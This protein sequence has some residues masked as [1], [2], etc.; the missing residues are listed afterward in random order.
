[1]RSHSLL[2]GIFPTQGSNPGLL[3][4]RWILYQLSHKGSPRI[5]EWV[6]YPF[7]SESFWPRNQSGFF[8]IAGGF[9][10]NWTIREAPKWVGS[11]TKWLGSPHP[12]S[13]TLSLEK[14]VYSFLLW[15]FLL[16]LNSTEISDPW[17]EEPA[18]PWGCKESY[19]TEWLTHT[20][21][22]YRE[23][24]MGERLYRNHLGHYLW[25]PF[26]DRNTQP[27]VLL[28]AWRSH[29]P[30]IRAEAHTCSVLRIA[31]LLCVYLSSHLHSFFSLLFLLSFVRELPSVRA[32]DLW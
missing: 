9:F 1:M 7:S 5:L 17:T 21:Q 32:G 16:S 28:G 13:S 11:W 3:L 12:R 30:S 18:C 2:Q 23:P 31:R 10:T 25:V 20:Q 6:A 15:W 24:N 4:C 19:T 14:D 22:G 29:W 26:T 27:C 8:C